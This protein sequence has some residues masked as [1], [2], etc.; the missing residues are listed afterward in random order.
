MSGSIDA[1]L[2]QIRAAAADPSRPHGGDERA[3]LEA[4]AAE[5]ES[6]L[7]VQVLRDMRRSGR[8]EDEQDGGLDVESLF[9]TLDVEL[10][11]HLAKTQ[12][13]GLS[14]EL[15]SAFE[16][17]NVEPVATTEET[18]TSGDPGLQSPPTTDE[19]RV[20]PVAGQVTSA[21]GWRR[22]PFTG[23]AKF[24]KG[25]DLRAAYGEQVDA[26]SAGRV[27]FSGDQGGYG[28]TVVLEHADGTRTR[29]AH[30]SAAAVA[31]GDQVQAGQPIGRAGSSGRATG[32]HL[33]FEVLLADGRPVAPEGIQGFLAV[34]D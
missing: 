11:S 27:V 23:E 21:F 25:V 34:A 26:A 18:H 8:W 31:A 9:E 10:A 3:R 19:T 7:L 14:R 28:T 1:V 6:M 16:R 32:A 15:I 13:L 24:H 20:P 5:F 17:M 29:Y 22:D 2:A 4:L 12:G 30:L 33:H